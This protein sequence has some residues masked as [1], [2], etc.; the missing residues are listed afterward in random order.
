MKYKKVAIGL[1]LILLGGL[2]GSLI[3]IGGGSFA[4]IGCLVGIVLCCLL[5][6][7]GPRSTIS[8]WLSSSDKEQY[9]EGEMNAQV[10]ENRTLSA[11]EQHTF[12]E[13]R[14]LTGRERF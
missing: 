2:I 3:P 7:S 4:F 5:I 11:R 10:I 9:G 13:I 12:D 14:G 6:D 1:G 8:R